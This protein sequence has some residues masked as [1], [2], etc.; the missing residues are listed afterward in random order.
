MHIFHI[1]SWFPCKKGPYGGI[2]CENLIRCL[3]DGYPDT[4]H[5]VSLYQETFY[6]WL[7][8]SSLFKEVVGYFKE[9]DEVSI[10][11]K[12]KN[13]DYFFASRSIVY[14]TRLG[15]RERPFAYKRHKENLEICI[16]KKGKPD[17][18]HAQV[19][20]S[21]G[22]AAWLLS[23]E[24][25]IPYI[26]TERFAPFPMPEYL[27]NGKLIDD[28]YKPLKEASQIISVSPAFAKIIEQYCDREVIAIPNFLDESMFKPADE[29][30]K[31]EDKRFRFATL[32]LNYEPRKGVDSLISAIRIIKDNGYDVLF[33]IGGGREDFYFDQVKQQAKELKVEQN[34]EW[35]GK[36]DRPGV[37]DLMQNCDCFVLPSTS[38]SFGTVYIEAMACGKPVIATRC[39]GPESIVNDI[40]GILVPVSDPVELANALMRMIDTYNSY[41]SSVIRQEFL[42]RFSKKVITEKYFNI[43]KNLLNTK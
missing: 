3:S 28:I 39:G 23:K 40:N 42:K 2:S 10:I 35:F 37:V 7:F 43:Y 16:E 33:R 18:I 12:S 11:A 5:S 30:K 6:W 41:N 20:N 1:P 4:D 19:T 8:N 15:F 25:N 14:S 9:K 17:L 34:I 26:I 24:F 22:Y 31:N 32:T 29:F 13:L 21:G 27:K 38:E 36:L